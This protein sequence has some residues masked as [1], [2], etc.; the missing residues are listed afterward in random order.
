MSSK[1]Y[2]LSY[3]EKY[4]L[5]ENI[6][7]E[8]TQT[9]IVSQLF[10]E[11]LLSF[12][13]DLKSINE[14][15]K[16][17][18]PHS[19]N[20][21]LNT[22][23]NYTENSNINY[24]VCQNHTV[25]YAFIGNDVLVA[26][27]GLGV[28]Y[29]GT[30]GKYCNAILRFDN[31]KDKFTTL[32]NILTSKTIKK[33]EVSL[34]I[35]YEVLL[36]DLMT[37]QYDPVLYKHSEF[38]FPCQRGGVCTVNG[39]FILL[40]YFISPELTLKDINNIRNS[41]TL[42]VLKKTMVLDRVLE[43]LIDTELLV[44][45]SGEEYVLLTYLE[46]NLSTFDDKILESSK[47][48]KLT[49]SEKIT[50]I[51]K[52]YNV[53]LENLKGKE[54]SIT[55]VKH[56]KEIPIVEDLRTN[57]PKRVKYSF[58]IDQYS[59]L[60]SLI[61]IVY[62]NVRDHFTILIFAFIV[63][64]NKDK[65]LKLVQSSNEKYLIASMTIGI[66][67][68][69]NIRNLKF[70]TCF[71]EIWNKFAIAWNESFT[72]VSKKDFEHYASLL[73][74][75][76]R[77]AEIIKKEIELAALSNFTP[78]AFKNDMGT[79]HYPNSVELVH[80]Q[81]S[82]EQAQRLF[83]EQFLLEQVFPGNKDALL[84]VDSLV[85]DRDNI[86]DNKK[87]LLQEWCNKLEFPENLYQ[88]I[89][90]HILD[91]FG[92]IKINHEKIW[93]KIKVDHKIGKSLGY[94]NDDDTYKFICEFLYST[95]R[96]T[97]Q[98]PNLLNV[99][100]NILLT[101]KDSIDF[102]DPLYYKLKSDDLEMKFVTNDNFKT[103]FDKNIPECVFY[104]VLVLFKQK[105]LTGTPLEYNELNSLIYH[106]SVALQKD[107]FI[108]LFDGT[109][110]SPEKVL[111]PMYITSP[112]MPGY[113]KV[114]DD[115]LKIKTRTGFET[116]R[117]FELKD[118]FANNYILENYK[119][120][121]G[122]ILNI[123]KAVPI[124][125]KVDK[126]IE[127]NFNKGT[128]QVYDKPGDLKSYSDKD[129]TITY[130]NNHLIESFY[131]TFLNS[132]LEI[133]KDNLIV[134][135]CTKRYDR[136]TVKIKFYICL[137]IEDTVLKFVLKDN[138][139]YF[140]KKEIIV[141]NWTK[142][143]KY[144]LETKDELIIIKVKNMKEIINPRKKNVFSDK[145]TKCFVEPD[146]LA[147]NKVFIIQKNE[148][149]L[150][151]S[152]TDLEPLLAFYEYCIYYENI[153][154]LRFLQKALN[155]NNSLSNEFYKATDSNISICRF[156]LGKYNPSLEPLCV[157]F[158]TINIEVKDEIC[159]LDELALDFLEERITKEEYLQNLKVKFNKLPVLA[160]L[161][162]RKSYKSL[163]DTTKVIKGK[164][165][166][167][168]YI[169]ND[170]NAGA[171]FDRYTKIL[172]SEQAEVKNN[173][174]F[175]PKYIFKDKGSPFKI[176]DNLKLRVKNKD[177]E[178]EKEK[179]KEINKDKEKEKEKEKEEVQTDSDKDLVFPEEEITLEE[180]IEYY[181][182][183][184][185]I[186]IK[187]DRIAL[188]REVLDDL[189]NNPNSTR[190]HHVLMGKGKTKIFAPIIALYIVLNKR[191]FK[192]RNLLIVCPTR[193]VE[194]SATVIYN[195][196]HYIHSE[197]Y[198]NDFNEFNIKENSV[199]VVS[200]FAIKKYFLENVNKPN[201]DKF[202]K[203]FSENNFVIF[204][205]VDYLFNNYSCE[206]NVIVGSSN[207][208]NVRKYFKECSDLAKKI[209]T[210]EKFK[211]DSNG[212]NNNIISNI[213]ESK[214]VNLNNVLPYVQ[215]CVPLKDYGPKKHSVEPTTQYTLPIK[216][217]DGTD[218]NK[219]LPVLSTQPTNLE[220]FI[221]VPYK[222]DLPV[223]NSQFSDPY[224]K[225][226]FTF[227]YYYNLENN[228]SSENVNS[229]DKI[230]NEIISR[231]LDSPF[232]EEWTE[233]IECMKNKKDNYLFYV[234]EY[235]LDSELKVYEKRLNVSM[236]DVSNAIENKVGFSGT[237]LLYEPIDFTY[238]KNV[239]DI[240]LDEKSISEIFDN[241]LD[242][243]VIVKK[244]KSDNDK[245][246]LREYCYEE[247]FTCK[248]E[249]LIDV[250]SFFLGVELKEIAERINS[251]NIYRKIHYCVDGKDY[252]LNN[253]S[254]LSKKTFVIFDRPNIVG[255]DVKMTREAVGLVT[256][257]NDVKFTELAQG[258]YRLRELNAKDILGR[259]QSFEIITTH[260]LT[261]RNII[262]NSIKL[263]KELYESMF[264]LCTVQTYRVA[265]RSL[266]T[267]TTKYVVGLGFNH[268]DK[269]TE[270]NK[271]IKDQNIDLTKIKSNRFNNYVLKELI[272]SIV[273]SKSLTAQ[274]HGIMIEQEKEKELVDDKYPSVNISTLELFE[275][276]VH[277]HKL[278]II[279]SS[280]QTT[281]TINF[282]LVGKNTFMVI[283][284]F[285]QE[286]NQYLKKIKLNYTE[287]DEFYSLYLVGSNNL[288]FIKD[289]TG[290]LYLTDF[291]IF[292][293][294]SLNQLDL[295]P[296]IRIN[297]QIIV[298][299][300]S[301]KFTRE[302]QELC[303]L[304]SLVCFVDI[305]KS[306]W[307]NCINIM[308]KFKKSLHQNEDTKEIAKVLNS[309]KY[310]ML[311]DIILYKV[312][313]LLENSTT[314]HIGLFEKDNPKY[315]EYY[316]D[317]TDLLYDKYQI[318]DIEKFLS[319]YN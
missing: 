14:L 112:F 252:Y 141:T 239:K 230:I 154:N 152:S 119:F 178:E 151:L 229:L 160:P 3:V 116:V 43:S 199:S 272:Y 220:E 30:Y 300:T 52:F 213:V 261:T 15:N 204:D 110:I 5:F 2:K 165:I 27:G 179:D 128:Y 313:E 257:S 38:L 215:S 184:F 283:N 253:Y 274:S 92:Y 172:N 289:V 256:Y 21:G 64:N 176:L 314:N 28:E 268:N 196:F 249:C 50:K 200:D 222:D 240:E 148:Y 32:L 8:G 58:D 109:I 181:E 169:V 72:Y 310:N 22:F 295:F 89:S 95:L 125:C 120:E 25:W 267:L 177:K 93:N 7:F 319:K 241:I 318:T 316:S 223:S 17:I 87:K 254:S 103:P 217:T 236:Y 126:T 244:L 286:H 235:I 90:W 153:F 282:G 306:Q 293:K 297:G 185:R 171:W 150:Q 63:G 292:S 10:N 75:P 143:T 102:W 288:F 202:L 123:V 166:I 285:V 278:K 305:V 155:K 287:Y 187:E 98:D 304:F 259:R 231:V 225:I 42:F 258:I 315:K 194:Q 302:E 168:N 299:N 277:E 140:N 129:K 57:L 255:K 124:Q 53:T 37:D 174:E 46:N 201:S 130:V 94:R 16:I 276:N 232:K 91:H 132:K 13:E 19:F 60:G 279:S 312:N 180:V 134:Y 68:E 226:M 73:S 248:Y 191:K 291:T 51:K 49:C 227:L 296:I 117:N 264:K 26:N 265:F 189:V 183:I 175:N 245:L 270:I 294:N 269:M 56:I 65:F 106:D 266:S 163:S 135:K 308:D 127:Y 195:A 104:A 114:P 210:I 122:K 44:C 4:F 298:N 281:T 243:N 188:I 198:I 69:K 84:H 20:K 237:P 35:F 108:Y 207:L 247:I 309:R 203:T 137:T 211:N 6:V 100:L 260:N 303:M 246:S 9:K 107:G 233:K 80:M 149:D 162:D 161:K 78:V 139:L 41:F 173:L 209:M 77:N 88:A 79:Q 83:S 54:I 11:M 271:L 81:K 301:D 147:K 47:R 216:P 212:S 206:F 66:M 101:L 167:T 131:T 197:I 208:G 262:E 23:K 251:E 234:V 219:I 86:N 284:S 205:E 55:E 164:N 146:L 182:Y 99:Q 76:H 158:E 67:S 228:V 307:I 85:H 190:F 12:E 39:A 133:F 70:F 242:K 145:E 138:K 24:L 18:S 31:K 121:Y 71:E 40:M 144:C 36:R 105:E 142:F 33:Q 61:D 34:K 280:N 275:S 118:I 273:P 218:Q 186:K 96:K 290:N 115:E 170:I 113:L 250:A 74:D 156:L 157:G 97:L 111:K 192:S 29:H 214:N 1:L 317:L 311:H 238:Q 221:V 62:D 193:L 59:T 159:N 45:S 263:E 136:E 82:K 48:F 224:I